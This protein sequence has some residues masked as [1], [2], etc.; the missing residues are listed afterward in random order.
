[1]A[2]DVK[3]VN[4]MDEKSEINLRRIVAPNMNINS[5]LDLIFTRFYLI[6]GARRSNGMLMIIVGGLPL[7]IQ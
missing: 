5:H 6:I 1:M 4:S 3:I 2:P 7:K